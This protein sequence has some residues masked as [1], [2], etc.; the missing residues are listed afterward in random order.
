M[1][2]GR[3]IPGLYEV[4]IYNQYGRVCTKQLH[5]TGAVASIS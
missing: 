5:N 1:G 2:V 4:I 3:D